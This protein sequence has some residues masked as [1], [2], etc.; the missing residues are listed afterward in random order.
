[1]NISGHFYISI[2]LAI[3][4]SAILGGIIE[5]LVIRPMYKL[6]HIYQFITT[7]GVTFIIMD[8]AKIIWGGAYHVIDYPTYLQGPIPLL[9][10]MLPKYNLALIILGFLVF[11]A[12]YL[13]INKTHFGLVIRGITA[14]RTMMSIFGTDVSWTYTSVFMT[15]CALV[16]LA[17]A[18]I[19]PITA[20]GPG[21]DVMVLLKG[22]IVIVIGGFGSLGGA[23]LASM[24]IGL[25]NA[26][27]ILI[28]PK[29]ALGFPFFIMVIF[30]IIRPW[31]L[32][33]KPIKL[34]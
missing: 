27:G 21:M 30:L 28:V 10:L 1:M 31:G 25:A 20:A 16:G 15:G 24:I 5:I 17:A 9:G 7:F 6:A 34:D 32:L 4:G 12:L 8:L 29:A 14:D 18:V 26:F 33:G 22:F 11:I 13:F 23:L 2:L 19:A 3:I